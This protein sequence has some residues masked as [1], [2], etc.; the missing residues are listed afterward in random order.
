[1][2]LTPDYQKDYEIIPY[3]ANPEE[4]QHN[5]KA[6]M[7]KYISKPFRYLENTVGCEINFNKEFYEPEQL[8]SVHEI[9]D[10]LQTLD[11]HLR[12]LE[13]ELAL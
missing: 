7:A 2:E 12:I 13:E 11:E 5:I 8:R 10:D 3:R 6:F 4:N 1:M 9:L